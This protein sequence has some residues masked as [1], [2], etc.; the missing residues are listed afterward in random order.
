MRDVSTGDKLDRYEIK[1][2]L[3]RNGVASIYKALDTESG[4]TVALKVPHLQFEHDVEFLERFRREEEIGQRL[5]HPNIVKVLAPDHKSQMYLVMEYVDGS[6]LRDVLR[7]E[8]KLPVERALAIAKELCEAVAYLHGH[9]IVHRNLKPENVVLTERG[10]VKVL[11]FGVA[12]DQAARRVTWAGL[13]PA[14]ISDY[15]AP[16]QIGG[17]R[18]DA[19][20]DVYAC[21]TMIYEML[22][23]EL[24]FSGA[25]ANSVVPAK[26][27]EE[28]RPLR[29][30]ESGIDPAV[31]SIVMKCIQRSPADRYDSAADLLH[32][33]RNP[34]AV[35][36]RVQ[37]ASRWSGRRLATALVVAAILAMLAL[38]IGIT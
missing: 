37:P 18:G 24:P 16:E 27:S 2:L 19:R 31:E 11:G 17:R 22:S 8:G 32:D 36:A 20:T 33:L 21:G 9:G 29:R 13:S 38:L 34:A 30:L 10:Q 7:Q 1:G 12:L 35:T 14:E 15:T 5:E 4:S 6:S 23:G 25:K 3:A 26:T 28:P